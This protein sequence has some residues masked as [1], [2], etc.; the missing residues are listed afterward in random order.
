MTEQ[1]TE[2]GTSQRFLDEKRD[3]TTETSWVNAPDAG[4][5]PKRQGGPQRYFV[6]ERLRLH[7]LPRAEAKKGSR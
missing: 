7:R 4:L 5:H 1:A 3:G 6:Q 2:A